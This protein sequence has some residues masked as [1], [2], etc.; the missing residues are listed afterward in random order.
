[1]EST[2]A[3]PLRKSGK[4][5][6]HKIRKWLIFI[7]NLSS[8]GNHVSPDSVR[9]GCYEPLLKVVREGRKNGELSKTKTAEDL[10]NTLIT[11]A[12][13]LQQESNDEETR[14]RTIET[15]IRLIS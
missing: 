12:I 10:T 7:S 2:L 9:S 1:M 6:F 8:S 4:K 3:E 11:F 5:P 15:L 13:G 14:S